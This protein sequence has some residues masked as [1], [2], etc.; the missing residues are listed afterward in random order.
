MKPVLLPLLYSPVQAF[1]PLSLRGSNFGPQV[2]ALLQL[3]PQSHSI[4]SDNPI[5]LRTVGA[6]PKWLVMGPNS[7]LVLHKASSPELTCF[8]HLLQSVRT[9]GPA[10]SWKLP[11]DSVDVSLCH[12]CGPPGSLC[13]EGQL[14]AYLTYVTAVTKG[15]SKNISRK[16]IDVTTP[17]FPNSTGYGK[18]RAPTR[19]SVVGCRNSLCYIYGD[20]HLTQT[21]PRNT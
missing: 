14:S 13:V 16:K 6:I 10:S 17:P 15:D 12:V 20:F 1:C 2:S 9:L 4:Q 11:P 7:E 19:Q 21:L 5:S 8:F 3:T 18:Y